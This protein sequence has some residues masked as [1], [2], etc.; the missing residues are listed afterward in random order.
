MREI[1]PIKNQVLLE[2]EKIAIKAISGNIFTLISNIRNGA[3]DEA[4]QRRWVWELL[5]NAMDTTNSERTTNVEIL[6]DNLN[7]RLSFK[8]N[9]NPFKIY[10]ITS[11]VNQLSSKPR[12]VNI[13]ER[14]RTI[15]KF[16]TG[17]I[18][19]H[20]L[21]EK[22]T[23]KSTVDADE[24]GHKYFT[25]LLDRSGKDEF[26]LYEAVNNSMEELL[27][28]D[29]L[30]NVVNYNYSELN[31]EF[32]YHLDNNGINVAKKGIDDLRRSLPFTMAFVK[33]INQVEIKNDV[34]YKYLGYEVIYENIHLHNISVS[35]EKKIQ[36]LTIESLTED[37]TIAIEV[38]FNDNRIEF[39]ALEE[40][41]P[42]LFCNYPFIGTE[43]LNFPVVFN[44]S[45][46]NV[47][48]ERR[49]GITL[50]DANTDEIFENKKLIIE[51][52]NLFLK[53]L[54][55]LTNNDFEFSNTY[56]LANFTKP[57]E[58]EWLSKSWYENFILQPIQ[59][60]L[61]K[62][63]IVEVLEDGKI[64]RRPIISEN[65]NS[66]MFPYHK[67]ESIRIEIYDLC[68]KTNHFILPLFDHIHFWHKMNWW[69]EKHYLSIKYLGTWFSSF[70][71]IYDVQNLIKIE[72]TKFTNWCEELFSLFNKDEILI[73]NI[74]QNRL[75]VYPN[76]KGVLLTKNRI[77]LDNGETPE[78]L[79]DIL[80]L[81]NV[82]IREILLDINLYISGG[83]A[84]DKEKVKDVKDIVAQI[85][86]Q[87]SKYNSD[88]M[89]GIQL[90]DDIQSAFKTLYLW[91]CSNTNYSE[92]FGDLYTNKETRLLDEATIKSSI[93][94]DSKTIALLEKYGIS[95]I[96][97][98]EKLIEKGLPKKKES[99]KPENLLV[100]LGITSVDD[101]ERA[102]LLFADNKEITEALR[103]IS[104]NDFEKLEQVLKLIK[105]SKE[106]VKRKLQNHPLYD[107]SNWE[108]SSLT[109]IKGI[110]KNGLQIKLVIRPG[111]GEQIILFYPEEYET[112]D[113]N[114]NELW[115][116]NEKE[117]ALYTFGRFLKRAKV[118]KM[119]I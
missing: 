36:V 25:I 116:D 76:Q 50:K 91:L 47:Y 15:G 23:L 29:T 63:K 55:F 11:L 105:R 67:E 26:A 48:Q 7:F 89:K 22:V 73:G 78:E 30:P 111:D 69:H 57:N 19:T 37:A 113:N 28:L 87:V 16:G 83:I 64:F 108:E 38:K 31:T 6:I 104:S 66:I 79:K 21:S 32:I 70:A 88:K 97:D 53:L 17:F 33:T 62:A 82:D 72:S 18:T 93:E 35:N 80:L 14:K 46:F 61:L 102:K 20:L 100:S 3:N 56:V 112:L 84:I 24:S 59:E 92:L 96:D 117:Q 1:N 81:L 86:E 71:T 75:R 65:G 5:Q 74:N 39:V 103:H 44:S 94:R 99:L 68:K 58:F 34:V 13:N 40:N 60:N 114:I 90:S 107:C 119:P 12:S 49:N 43:Y 2:N 115:Y 9:G 101:L 52:K 77:Y 85:K 118:S 54:S 106:N 8:H 95:N 98:L 45:S 51:C 27:N 41:Q 110:V 109:T 10:N 4:Y 42:R